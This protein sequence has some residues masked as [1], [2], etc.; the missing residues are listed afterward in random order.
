MTWF[1][2]KRTL[3][4]N[5]A[6][7][8]EVLNP[9]NQDVPRSNLHTPLRY[10]AVL[11]SIGKTTQICHQNIPLK[12][13]HCNGTVTYISAISRKL[14]KEW[15]Q[16]SDEIATMLLPLLDED[17]TQSVWSSVRKTNDGWL[18]FVISKRGIEYWQRQLAQWPLYPP[19]STQA[20][21][22]KP[23]QLWHLQAGYELCCRWRSRYR[24]VN[25]QGSCQTSSVGLAP[26][27]IPFK[28]LQ[29]LIHCLLDI[30]D[31]WD[32]TKASKLLQQVQKLVSALEN[33]AGLTELSSEAGTIG[34]WLDASR[35]VLQQSLHGRLGYP[36]AE[37]L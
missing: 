6:S 15:Q 27:Q 36:L 16:P 30:C 8:I 19:P 4:S 2:L 21:P 11:L 37:R 34:P 18:E 24:L 1:S 29:T 22:I 10:S 3:Q 20:W 23:E 31:S 26:F 35:I 13:V 14:A 17:S 32:Q 28:P 33:C 5:L 9:I 25:R 12:K 7:S